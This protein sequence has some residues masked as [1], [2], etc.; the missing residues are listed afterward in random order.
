MSGPSEVITVHGLCPADGLQVQ[1]ASSSLKV[2]TVDTSSTGDM[3]TFTITRAPAVK[4]LDL[5]G[6]VTIECAA[7]VTQHT[8]NH[9]H[10]LNVS[11]LCVSSG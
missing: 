8:Q 6:T 5:G 1:A 10:P 7:T 11:C 3:H 9:S 4:L 2:G